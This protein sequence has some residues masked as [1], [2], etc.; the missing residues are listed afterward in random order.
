MNLF[1]YL[2]KPNSPSRRPSVL[3]FELGKLHGDSRST[4]DVAFNQSPVG[5]HTL[6]TAQLLNFSQNEWRVITTMVALYIG[7]TDSLFNDAIHLG[8]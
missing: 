1:L 5:N 6:P 3:F 2:E 8:L 7:E 4:L